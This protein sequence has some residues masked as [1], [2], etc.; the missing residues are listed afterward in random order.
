MSIGE[1]IRK[2]RK[3]KGL[4]QEE[5]AQC[6]GVTAPAVNK[7]ESGSTM[8][9]I[10]LLAPIARLLSISLDE[11]LSFRE[12]LSEREV[13]D[14]IKEAECRAAS[15]RCEDTFQWARAQIAA[16]PNCEILVYSLSVMLD[17]QRMAGPLPDAEEHDSFILSCYERLLKSSDE[18]MRT[19][20]AE[21]LYGYYL[22]REDFEKAE[23]YLSYFSKQNPER[24]RKQAAIYEKA[25]RRSEAYKAYEEILFAGYQVMD[26]VLNSLCRMKLEEKDAKAARYYVEKRKALAALLEMSEYG[27]YAAELDLA[28]AERD[29]DQT[30][31][32]IE[33]L[34]G[35]AASLGAFTR[36]QLYAHM[37]C[38]EIDP[39]F[40]EKV[41]RL[42]VNAV[43]S[44]KGFAYMED[45]PR[46]APFLTV[47]RQHACEENPLQPR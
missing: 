40:A 34:L 36:S 45:D 5:M 47:A 33:G 25:G 19:A 3:S 14:L 38:K 13:R 31:A 15:D 42:I 29:R 23:A 35:S 30:M 8:P 6:L 2:N 41:K 10:M 46:W 12:E 32:C 44:D 21:S 26:T 9:D 39:S 20:A 18:A 24:K 11:L 22:R 16:Y 43:Q 28:Q 17:A 27:A 1:V 7:W 37:A 4:T